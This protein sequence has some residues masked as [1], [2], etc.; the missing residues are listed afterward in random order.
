MHLTTWWPKSLPRLDENLLA[1]SKL[2]QAGLPT[3][4]PRFRLIAGIDQVLK[5]LLGQHH[6]VLTGW[7]F[8]G[9]HVHLCLLGARPNGR[10]RIRAA[11][12]G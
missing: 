1:K 8:D 6:E 11:R 12:R 7:G 3:T 2:V 10:R 9:L 5:V 4:D